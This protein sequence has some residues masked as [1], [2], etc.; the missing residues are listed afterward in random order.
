MEAK[1]YLGFFKTTCVFHNW[2]RDEQGNTVSDT[3]C[4]QPAVA[5][6]VSDDDEPKG[7]YVCETHA[8]EAQAS[9]DGPVFWS[10]K[11]IVTRE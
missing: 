1:E 2:I 11:L 5:V 3:V 10:N 9:A 8:Q 7:R 6:Y 4:G